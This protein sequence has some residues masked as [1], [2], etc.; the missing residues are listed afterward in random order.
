MI[1]VFSPRLMSWKTPTARSLHMALCRWQL[2]HFVGLEPAVVYRVH[3]VS[4]GPFIRSMRI[5]TL[6]TIFGKEL[7]QVDM[8]QCFT[9][10]ITMNQGA[11]ASLSTD[12]I[13]SERCG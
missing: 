9:G 11:S 7:Q 1:P 13:W 8:S 5:K 12:R 4:D 10:I 3:I 6:F 2:F